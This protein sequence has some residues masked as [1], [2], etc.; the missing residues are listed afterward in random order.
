MYLSI[1]GGGTACGGRIIYY[2]LSFSLTLLTITLH[3]VPSS[4]RAPGTLTTV[5]TRRIQ[6]YMCIK[7]EG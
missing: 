3:I 6:L 2:Q 5:A 1:K 7:W 4:P